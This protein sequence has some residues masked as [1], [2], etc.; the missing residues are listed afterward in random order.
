MIESTKQKVTKKTSTEQPSAASK[1]VVKIPTK[2]LNE[3]VELLK[4]IRNTLDRIENRQ[5]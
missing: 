3:I 2:D 1:A 4:G 5:S